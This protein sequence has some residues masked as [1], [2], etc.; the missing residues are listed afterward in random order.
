MSKWTIEKIKKQIKFGDFVSL[1]GDIDINDK[2]FDTATDNAFFIYKRGSY[3]RDQWLE[4]NLSS[5]DIKFYDRQGKEILPEPEYKYVNFDSFGELCEWIKSDGD[6]Y[7]DGGCRSYNS[8]QLKEM[9]SLLALD[10][11]NHTYFKRVEI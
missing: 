3:S 8:S 6:I 7:C 2:I 5:F 10:Y 9:L 4:R 11:C 1:A